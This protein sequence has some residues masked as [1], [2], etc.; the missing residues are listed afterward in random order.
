[1]SEKKMAVDWLPCAFQR[2]LGYIK[3]F[4]HSFQF[5]F[6]SADDNPIL[7]YSINMGSV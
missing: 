7:D 6:Y 5:S 2:N 3:V 4:K 1:M